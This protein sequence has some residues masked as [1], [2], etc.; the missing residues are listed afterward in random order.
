[1]KTIYPQ[2]MKE[3]PAAKEFYNIYL[4]DPSEVEMKDNKTWILLR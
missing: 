1:M 2:I 4:T 3:H